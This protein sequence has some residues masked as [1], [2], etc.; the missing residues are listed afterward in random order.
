MKRPTTHPREAAMALI[1]A[2]AA[3]LP[4]A[5]GDSKPTG[6]TTTAPA[7]THQ[8]RLDPAL[9]DLLPQ[10]VKDRGDLRV[11]TD[12]SYAP[13]ES[14]APDGRTIIGMDPD[15][16][17]EIGRV[18][19]V[20]LQLEATDFDKLL[21]N[22]GSGSLDLAMSAMTDTPERA[23]IADF[24]DYFTAGTSIVVQRGN[25]AGVTELND[26]CGKVVA[27]ENATTQVDLLARTQNNCGVQ[28]IIVRTYPTNSDALLELRTGR[29]VAVLNDTPPAT[30]LVNDPRT[31]SQYQLASTMQYEPAPYG[32]A[33]AKSQPGLRDA[34]KGA[35]E[36]LLRSGVYADVLARWHVQTGAIA[37]ITV[38]SSR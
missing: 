20:R 9:H 5:C 30:F 16:A 1:L 38:N 8:A 24:V 33:V 31:S 27:V 6:S 17:V 18:L 37:Q 19:G 7:A 35:L 36:Q 29:A 11:G 28:R 10:S 22:L 12:A 3:M 13:I 15:L 14:Y 32:I 21:T 23:K 34:V 2:V 25:P 26:L 4:G